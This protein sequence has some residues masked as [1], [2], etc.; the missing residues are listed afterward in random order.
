[1]GSGL[2]GAGRQGYSPAVAKETRKLRRQQGKSESG[3][4]SSRQ[5]SA[6]LSEVVRPEIPDPFS[7]KNIRTTLIRTGI[8]VAVI[9]GIGAMVAG[10]SQSK[11]TMY[12]AL[13]I[14][15]VLTLVVV[16]IVIW[17]VRQTRK[18]Q[19]VASILA[20]ADTAEGREAAMA[21]LGKDYKEKDATAV[22]ARAQL[23]MQ[24][25]PGAALGILEQIDLGKV[26]PAVADE[27]RSQRA[28][29]H[30][31]LGQP[32]KARDLVDSIDLKR[33]Q[34][35]RS[36]AMMAAV[37]GEAWARTGQARKG[38]LTMEL[39]NP[40][41]EQYQ[42]L[43]P[44]LYRARAYAFAYINDVKQMR[45]ALKKLLDQ[46]ARLLGGFLGGK[47]HP[48]LQKEAKKMLEQSGQVPRKMQIQRKL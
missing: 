39:F 29:I 4:V 32:T 24:E 10:V 28:M 31:M 44:Q 5:G 37:I 13:G 9:W 2:R 20:T 42:Q 14:P 19:T 25:D 33:H 40:E 38:L 11:T 12:V 23:V 48:L 41:E 1:M 18:A 8:P 22:F 15:A 47:G 6:S 30:L 16:G 43:R 36:K 27:A 46:D 7:S 26:T 35:P 3:S 45:R 34:E 21:K 17:A